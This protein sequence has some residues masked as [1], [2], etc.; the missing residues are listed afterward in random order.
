MIPFTCPML[1]K[2]GVHCRGGKVSG[3]SKVAFLPHITSETTKVIADDD[4]GGRQA[5]SSTI[6][7]EPC[8]PNM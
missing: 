1:F 3:L 7:V 5:G 4:M 2:H 6:D 8:S